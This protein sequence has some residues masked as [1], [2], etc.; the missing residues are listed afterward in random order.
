MSKKNKT[1]A[2]IITLILA[3]FVFLVGFTNED[4]K[5]LN[6]K[7]QVYLD[8]NAI[9]IIS[10]TKELYALINKEQSE[11][12]NEYN[13][14]Q[15]YPPKG[16]EIESY[17]TYNDSLSSVGDI[18][19]K[20]KNSKSF[21]VKGYTATISE[22][23]NDNEEAKVKFRVNVLDK[24]I[25]EEAINNLI[26]SFVNTDK[27][28]AYINGDQ[29]E[30]KDTGSLIENIYFKENITIKE[31][32]LSI[33]DK[34]FKNSD[35]LT[36]FLLFGDINATKNYTIKRGDTIKSI[37]DE[38][39]LNTSEFLIANPQYK[40]ESNILAVGDVVNVALADPKLTLVSEEY[41]I[42][43]TE[44]KYDVD[45]KYDTTKPT[46]YKVVEKKGQNGIQRVAKHISYV[47]GAIQEESSIDQAHTYMLKEVV[48]ET[49]IRGSMN[50]ST[51]ITGTYIDN[52]QNWAWP[53]NSPYVISS[54]YG[55]RWGAFHA[56]QDITGTGYGSPIYSIGNGEV[57]YAGWGG[58]A[59]SDA[60]LNVVIDHKN[61][62]YSLYAHLSDTY[63]NTGDQVSRKQ[64]IG[65]MGKSGV[66]TGTHLHLTISIGAAPYQ[67]GYKFINPLD[68][69]K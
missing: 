35:E 10:D 68:L 21:T 65:A 3:V 28:Q 30:I 6:V 12:K 7:Y 11:I 9:G 36:K 60:G 52:G 53:T 38:N 42:E 54:G 13:V 22:Q 18:Y 16:F 26:K 55:W 45:V 33:D 57:L 4:N 64:K 19:N 48:N 50:Y 66:A 46:S 49:I 69:W 41:V 59:G 43:D 34:I 23:P 63:V 39:K 5:M 2:I 1:K 58:M 47:N 44:V 31:N 62:Y 17:L 29:V 32:Y 61:G 20:I 40:K 25:F 15:V 24:K 27:Y 51:N 37:S 67:P 56:G 8:G 14:D